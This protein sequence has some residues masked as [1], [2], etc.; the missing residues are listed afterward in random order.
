MQS[1][2]QNN[3]EY[4]ADRNMARGDSLSLLENFRSATKPELNMFK[5]F[6]EGHFFL[7]SLKNF[8]VTP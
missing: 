8:N 3:K 5:R 7:S 1:R 4:G 2:G 6:L